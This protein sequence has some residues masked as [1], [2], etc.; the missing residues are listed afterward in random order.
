MARAPINGSTLKWARESLHME[1]EELGSSANLSADRISEIEE[2]EQPTFKQL[3]KL[4]VKLDRSAAFF[5]APPP[6]VSDTPETVD[7]RGRGDEPASPLLTRE[8]RRANQYRQSF[9]ELTPELHETK[10]VDSIAL[11][12][13]EVRAREFRDA[14]GLVEASVPPSREPNQVFNFWRDILEQAGYLVFQTTRI[15]LNEF[16][17]LS[18]NHAKLPIIVV[19]GSDAPNGKVFTLFHEVAHLA[20]RTSGLCILDEDNSEE[21]IANTFAADFL[22]PR[23]QVREIEP[24]LRALGE[25]YV[26]MSELVAHE[27]RVSTL[28][29]GVRLKALGYLDD[30]QLQVLWDISDANWQRNRNQ[31]RSKR[32]NPPYWRIRMRDLGRTYVGTVSKAL[33]D[34]RVS[35][36]DATY[37]MN[38]R[39][40]AV[41]EMI[42]DYR[43]N[44]GRE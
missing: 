14:V 19:N 37:L 4:A 44:E 25:D 26:G 3:L 28:A 17:G 12:S 5:F 39:L 29:A 2:G 8:I 32:G 16:R 38:A 34:G 9:L 18:I 41:N 30:T 43:R 40:P 10:R 33:D 15:H 11:N 35:L 13:T 21:T 24:R 7:F 42:N 31:L 23:C 1:R 22:M 6:D 36:V 20:N 27:F